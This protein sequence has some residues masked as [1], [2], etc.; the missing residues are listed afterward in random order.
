MIKFSTI[1][2]N[3]LNYLIYIYNLLPVYINPIILFYSL[4]IILIL[5]YYLTVK[6]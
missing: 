1:S 5:L 6:I 2:M 4:I 3:I